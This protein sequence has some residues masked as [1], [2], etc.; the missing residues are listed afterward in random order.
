MKIKKWWCSHNYW[1]ERASKCTKILAKI[2]SS[3]CLHRYTTTHTRIRPLK[4][5]SDSRP[6][7]IDPGVRTSSSMRLWPY[8]AAIFVYCI[9]MRTNM[10]ILDDCHVG[11]ESLLCGQ[12][13]ELNNAPARSPWGIVRLKFSSHESCLGVKMGPCKW[14]SI[15]PQLRNKKLQRREPHLSALL[16][17][18]AVSAPKG[19]L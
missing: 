4:L 15:S 13:A 18:D 6:D 19:T 1:P 16:S 12:N 14:V 3:L 2:S 10:L 9:R 8:A 17:Q 5:L 11:P 7:N